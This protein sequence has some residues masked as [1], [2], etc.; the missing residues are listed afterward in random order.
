MSSESE[1]TKETSSG[2]TPLSVF[3]RY[4]RLMLGVSLMGGLG[5]LTSSLVVAQTDSPPIDTLGAPTTPPVAPPVEAAPYSPPSPPTAKPKPT[6]PESIVVPAARVRKPVA[7]PAPF[8]AKKP[9]VRARRPQAS[10]PVIVVPKK[11]SAGCSQLIR[12]RSLSHHQASQSHPQP[13]GNPGEC[14]NTR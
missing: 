2:S 5:L 1:M 10:A 7:P 6:A 14:E 11:T 8:S 9:A 3:Y 12:I 13:G 4:P